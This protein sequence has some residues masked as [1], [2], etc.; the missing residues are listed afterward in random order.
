V[1]EAGFRNLWTPFAELI[2]HESLSRAYEDTLERQA[3]L[4]RES[5]HMRALRGDQ[6]DHDPAY[7]PN[8][9]LSTEGWDLAW[10]PRT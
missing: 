7:N 2:R 9:A 10:P 4:Q 1:R 3:R 6:L 5:A 8:L